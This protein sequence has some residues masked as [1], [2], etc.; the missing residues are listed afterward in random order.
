MDAPGLTALRGAVGR[1]ELFAGEMFPSV[2][3][4]MMSRDL[5][6]QHPV[7]SAPLELPLS[8]Q[9][10]GTIEKLLSGLVTEISF[11][12]KGDP[13]LLWPGE[14]L[15]PPY[16]LYVDSVRDTGLRPLLV[17]HSL[18]DPANGIYARLS[19]ALG[20]AME[21]CEAEHIG[22]P[23]AT[24]RLLGLVGVGALAISMPPFFLS[25]YQQRLVR[26]IR[27]ENDAM[28]ALHAIIGEA[29]RLAWPCM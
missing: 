4:R 6:R 22:V 2:C 3:T 28:A 12:L 21:Y 23:G 9:G 29:R 19:T 26:L 15:P 27:D 24:R 1:F 17:D 7:L 11:C 16:P 13:Q 14:L 18:Y 8:E 25:E 5:R 20:M 10:V